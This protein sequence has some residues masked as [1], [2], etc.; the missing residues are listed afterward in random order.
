MRSHS[1]VYVRRLVLIAVCLLGGFT[2]LC[3][4]GWSLVMNASPSD[5]TLVTV[6]RWMPITL[7]V[8]TVLAGFFLLYL[9]VPADPEDFFLGNDADSTVQKMDGK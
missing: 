2:L 3:I 6:L 9:P 5:T 7:G 4:S 1:S 8:V